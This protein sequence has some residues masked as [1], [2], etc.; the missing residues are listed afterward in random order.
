MFFLQWSGEAME[1]ADSICPL[2]GQTVCFPSIPGITCHSLLPVSNCV[3]LL[4]F[5]AISMTGFTSSD[6][7]GCWQP[8]VEPRRLLCMRMHKE[9]RKTMHSK[10]LA[11]ST[12]F[13]D[14]LVHRPAHIS[15]LA[16]LLTCEDTEGNSVKARCTVFGSWYYY[17]EP[18][19]TFSC[20]MLWKAETAVHGCCHLGSH[21]LF[22][23]C[24]FGG[25]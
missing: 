5:Q 4:T 7:F 10:V 13:T 19:L 25:W 14:A 15:K 17:W 2:W 9:A 8:P 6:G 24:L 16:S 23:I 22:I 20:A 1:C 12:Y 3:L 11:A 21:R 18:E